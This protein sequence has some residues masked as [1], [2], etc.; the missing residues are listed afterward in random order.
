MIILGDL[1]KFLKSEIALLKKEYK[2]TH[3][4]YDGQGVKSV[5][6]KIESTIEKEQISTIV[7][8]TKAFVPSELL[9]YLTRLELRG[10]NFTS[11]EHFIEQRLNKC[12][13][14]KKKMI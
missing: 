12:F 11:I 2:L 14:H 8:N 5:I 6:E 10:I 1:Y 3:I 7:L 4:S 13:F 9:S